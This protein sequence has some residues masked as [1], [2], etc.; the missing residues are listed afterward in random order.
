M[1]LRV[2]ISKIPLLLSGAFLAACASVA[3]RLPEVSLP[4]LETEQQHQEKIA[5][6][7][8]DRLQERLSKVA[9]PILAANTEICPKTRRDIGART[10]SLKSYSKSLRAGAARERGAKDS[11]HVLYVIPGSS[12]ERAGIKRGDQLLDL[13]GNPISADGKAMRALMKADDAPDFKDA[14]SRELFVRRGKSRRSVSLTPAEV[15]DYKVKLSMRST[16]NAYA[17]GKEITITSGMMNFTKND[18]ELALIIGHELAHNTMGHIRK[19]VGNTILSGFATRYTR[20]FESES[21]YVGLYYLARAGYDLEGVEDV[22]RRMA[23]VGPRSVARA[24]THPTHADR[25]L[26]LAAARREITA[27]QA[28]GEP[29]IPN[30]KKGENGPLNAEQP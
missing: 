23:L 29:L 5:F 25:F 10:H 8:I 19:I 15:C 14:I 16:I 21:D 24:K 27:K 17:T 18:E 1:G 26:R 4:D 20:P 3:T 2:H 13:M 7:E 28:A 6:A 12:A 22:W 11:P 9:Y 30:F